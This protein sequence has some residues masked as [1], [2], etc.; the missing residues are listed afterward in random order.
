M[1]TRTIEIEEKNL[2]ITAEVQ[3]DGTVVEAMLRADH[4]EDTPLDC[5]HAVRNS[6]YYMA[7][8]QEEIQGIDWEDHWEERETDH[9]SKVKKVIREGWPA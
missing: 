4:M 7:R 2:T 8:V 6:K 1:I 5:T 9:L 3:R